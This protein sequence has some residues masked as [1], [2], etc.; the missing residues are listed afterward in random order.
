MEFRR[1]L[2]R[3]K[4]KSMKSWPKQARRALLLSNRRKTHSGVGIRAIS[5]IQTGTSGKL[6]GT[7]SGPRQLSDGQQWQ[8]LYP[9]QPIPDYSPKTFRSEERRVGNEWFST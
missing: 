5:L 1:V 8:W 2:F 9:P 4:L 7:H 6:F 3:S